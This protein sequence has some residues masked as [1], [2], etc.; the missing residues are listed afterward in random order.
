VGDSRAYLVH[1][2]Q[3]FRV[4][5]DHSMVQELVDLGLLTPAQAAHHPDANRITRAL[6][7]TEDVEVDL[8]PTP[9]HHVAGDAF[10]LC[11]D[12]LSDLV[13]DHEI[14]AI[15]GAEPAA[16]AVGKLIDLA[17]ARGGHDNVTV[18]V[19][20]AR[21]S[22]A[23]VAPSVAPT[24]VQTT[25]IDSTPIGSAAVPLF[26]GEP[27]SVSSTEP[28]APDAAIPAVLPSLPSPSRPAPGARTRRNVSLFLIAGIGLAIGALAVLAFL[29]YGHIAG[30]NGHRSATVSDAGVPLLVAPRGSTSAGDPTAPSSSANRR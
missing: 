5:K 22:A 21:E 23:G 11:S 3:I 12:G 30:R 1:E 4:T 18:M 19:L 8:R 17:N 13:E 10:V 16:Q 26:R 28:G 29:L 20:R 14:L 7:M 15:V 2:G 9:V 24:V 27:R 6:G 25:L